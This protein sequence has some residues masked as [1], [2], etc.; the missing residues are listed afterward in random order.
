MS[1][2]GVIEKIVEGDIKRILM[3][4]AGDVFLTEAAKDGD[5]PRTLKARQFLENAEYY[6]ERLAILAMVKD[7]QLTTDSPD[8][9]FRKA[10]EDVIDILIK[11]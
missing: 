9:Q 4:A 3:V 11:G 10:I 7:Q 1:Y 6:A 2:R 5:E 8:S